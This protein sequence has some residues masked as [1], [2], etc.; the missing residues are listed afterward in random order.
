VETAQGFLEMG[1]FYWNAGIFLW[2][3]RTI[4]EALREYEPEMLK[5][6]D[7]IA[8]AAGT[9][10]FA[11]VFERL[12][13]EISGKSIDYAVLERHPSV[14]V[15]EAPFE[16]DDVGNWQSLARIWGSDEHGNT[17][18]GRHLG[19]DTQGCIVCTDNEH[20]I[21]TAGLKNCIIVHT[22]HAT[23]A[24]NKEDEEALREIVARLQEMGW[25]QYL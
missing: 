2:R 4:L 24:A 5:H 3:A 9:P 16:W 6:T 21:V 23:L 13:A 25:A 18:I 15:I 7:T 14:A 19:L 11:E 12:F 20:L 1:G 10:Q 8:A 17:I 22:P